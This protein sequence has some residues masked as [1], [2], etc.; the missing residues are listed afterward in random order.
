M[1]HPSHPTRDG[2]PDLSGFTWLAVGLSLLMAVTTLAFPPAVA[3][4]GM[5]TIT[6][7]GSIVVGNSTVV[8]PF[9]QPGRWTEF[10]GKSSDRYEIHHFR[11]MALDESPAIELFVTTDKRDEHPDGVF[12]MGLVQGFVKG[13]ASNTGFTPE[14][15]VFRE[16]SIGTA[17]T[18]NASVKLSNGTRTLRVYAYVYPRKPSLTF[19]TVTAREGVE[20]GIET[21]LSRLDVR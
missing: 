21:Y 2:G 8:P 7:S 6:S 5:T 20:E 17:K 10:E 18:L 4:G 15:P 1:K 14:M 13:F 9:P 3:H 12:E 16:R 11:Y 19:I